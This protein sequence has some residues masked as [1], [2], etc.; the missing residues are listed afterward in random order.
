MNFL[1]LELASLIL[2]RREVRSA[3]PPRSKCRRPKAMSPGFSRI[4]RDA[5]L[6][7][8]LVPPPKWWGVAGTDGGSIGSGDGSEVVPAQFLQREPVE[9]QVVRR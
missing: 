7:Q 3:R 8:F 4:S 5:C 2:N 1:T 9:R 6:G